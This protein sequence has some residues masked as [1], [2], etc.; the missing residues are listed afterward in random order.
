[1]NGFNA[2][3]SDCIVSVVTGPDY[4]WILRLQH[5]EEPWRR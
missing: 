5:T 4:S 3:Y 1:V 2:I